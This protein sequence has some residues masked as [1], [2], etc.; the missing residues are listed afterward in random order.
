MHREYPYRIYIPIT[1][2]CFLLS[3]INISSVYSEFLQT[4][5]VPRLPTLVISS[6]IFLSGI[7]FMAIGIV[8]NS[9]DNLRY[10]QRKIAYLM[11]SIN[12]DNNGK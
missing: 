1:L 8:L 5:F 12:K 3:I 10:E 4:G 9:I 7:F 11:S 6:S 2:I